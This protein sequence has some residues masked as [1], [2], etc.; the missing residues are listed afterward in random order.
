MQHRRNPKRISIFH[1]YQ[2]L[3]QGAAKVFAA[4]HY[5]HNGTI[6][7]TS[8]AVYSG[9]GL[10]VGGAKPVS[11][12]ANSFLQNKIIG[13]ALRGGAVAE[14]S[15]DGDGVVP[16]VGPAYLHWGVGC[17]RNKALPI[18]KVYL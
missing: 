5:L 14:R 12:A 16:G 8:Y 17:K 2:W 10:Y 13:L 4:V 18:R 15:A 11:C 9:K 1:H 6:L 7:N 3:T